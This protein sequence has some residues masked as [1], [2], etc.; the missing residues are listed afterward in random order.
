MKTV[1][2]LRKTRHCGRSLVEWF[3]VLTAT[4][5]QSRS[6]SENS[7]GN[8]MIPPT[9]NGRSGQ[10]NAQANLPQPALSHL[11]AGKTGLP[12]APRVDGSNGR[13]N[14]L[15]PR[16]ANSSFQRFRRV[17]NPYPL[18]SFNPFFDVVLNPPV[19]HA[20]LTHAREEHG[21]LIE[22]LSDSN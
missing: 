15:I 5:I 22:T 18:V 13:R 21:T 1:G 12:R 10:K 7:G 8:G 11:S 19:L 14:R 17:D 3:F 20:I 16:A 2:G 9:L 4:A 6:H